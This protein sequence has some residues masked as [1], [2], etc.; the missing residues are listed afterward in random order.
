[1]AE[2]KRNIAEHLCYTLSY[3]RIQNELQECSVCLLC[4]AKNW[5]CA[6]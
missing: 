3:F 4:I 6:I 5:N 1:M 2:N